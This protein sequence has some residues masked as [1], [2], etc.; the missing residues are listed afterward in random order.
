MPGSAGTGTFSP[1]E[2]SRRADHTPI[3]QGAQLILPLGSAEQRT[4]PTPRPGEGEGKRGDADVF[5]LLSDAPFR[6]DSARP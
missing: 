2:V 3:R 1:E 4:A 5:Y 6:L